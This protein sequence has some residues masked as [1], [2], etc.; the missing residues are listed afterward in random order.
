MLCHSE[1]MIEAGPG[2][3]VSLSAAS[4][5]HGVREGG[6]DTLDRKRQE[7][8]QIVLCNLRGNE[9]PECQTGSPLVAE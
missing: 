8:T 4:L 5:T 2:V 6:P 1:A 7:A 3:R 9:L